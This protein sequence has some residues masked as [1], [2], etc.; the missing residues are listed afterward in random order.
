MS[1]KNLKLST[2]AEGLSS[3]SFTAPISRLSEQVDAKIQQG[4]KIF[5]CTLGDFSPKH[6]PIP[7]ELENEIINAY[8]EKHTNYPFIGG[9]QELRTAIAN[10]IKL[11]GQFNYE[12]DA[13][14]VASGRASLNLSFV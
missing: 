6:F 14:I 10:H 9:M 8:R 5:N 4:E 1:N 7:Q 2:I 3:D 13:I 11:F 12:P